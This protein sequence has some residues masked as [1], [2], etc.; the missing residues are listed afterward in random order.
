MA[1]TLATQPAVYV[2]RAY[3]PLWYRAT[4]DIMSAEGHRYEFVLKDKTGT[5]LG[6]AKVIANPSGVGEFDASGIVRSYLSYDLKYATVGFASAPSS[7]IEIYVELKESVSGGLVTSVSNIGTAIQLNFSTPFEPGTYFGTGNLISGLTLPGLTLSSSGPFYVR[8]ITTSSGE[9]TSFELY[10]AASGGSPITATGTFSGPG[11]VQT[12]DY[13]IPRQTSASSTNSNKALVINSTA[14]PYVQLSWSD[15][16]DYKMNAV[17]SLPLTDYDFGNDIKGVAAATYES[18]SLLQ[19]ATTNIQYAFLTQFDADDNYLTSSINCTNTFGYSAPNW[20]NSH[21]ARIDLGIGPANLSLDPLTVRYQVQLI[22]DN[23]DLVGPLM[24]F[25]IVDFCNDDVRLMWLNYLGGFDYAYFKLVSEESKTERK[26]FKKELQFNDQANDRG[27][28]VY[29]SQSQS[30]FTLSS[31]FLSDSEADW[32]QSLFESPEVYRMQGSTF[33]P[34]IVTSDT[35]SRKIERRD[36]LK[37][38]I[39]QVKDANLK[40]GNP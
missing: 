3:T 27:E 5:V 22:D 24:R 2:Q 4:S 10:D 28:T 18:V 33:T 9:V 11:Y 8:N 37:Q 13:G 21:N 6:T 34:V 19:D 35:Y 25:K 7:L 39:I 30:T 17:G 23:D 1:L 15:G 26:T 32:M 31:R 36:R 40:R 16:D 29:H 20:T 14:S 38:Y 12:S